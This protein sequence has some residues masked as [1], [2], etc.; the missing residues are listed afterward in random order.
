MNGIIDRFE[1]DY[2]VVEFD[3]R[4]MKDIPKSKIAIGAKAGDVIVLVDGKYQVDQVET[5]RRKAEITKLT[6]NM[7][8]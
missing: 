7:W 8:E 6:E 4:Q 3:G 1:G 5:Q 2:A